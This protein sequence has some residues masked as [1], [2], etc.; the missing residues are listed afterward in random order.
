VRGGVLAGFFTGS[1]EMVQEWINDLSRARIDMPPELTIEYALALGLVGGFED[2][3]AWLARAQVALADDAPP[4]LRARLAM[5]RAITIGSVGEIEPAMQAAYEARAIVERG[6]DQLIDTGSRHV[7]LRCKLFTGDHAAARALFEEDRRL[8]GD[9]EQLDRVILGGMF[10]QVELESGDLEAARVAAERSVATVAKLDAEGHRGTN[11]A[12][13]T[14]G[15]LAYESDQLDAA[16]ALFDRCVTLVWRGRPIFMLLARIELARIWNARGEI[17][18][19][20]V[21][22]DRARDA[23][24]AGIRSPLIDRVEGYRA[25]LLAENDNIAVARDIVERLPTGRQQSVAEIRLDLAE[26][27]ALAAHATLEQLAGSNHSQRE[28]LEFALLDA[29]VALEEST[30]DLEEKLELVLDLGR[31]AGFIRTIADEGPALATALADTLRRQPADSYADTLAPVLERTIAAASARNVPL[32]GGVMLSE[33]ELTV[34]K[35]LATRLATREIAAELYVSMNTFRTHTKS[36]YR[37]LGVDSRAGAVE[38][39]R[40]LGIL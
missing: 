22:L 40:G 39:A 7:L 8:P 19:A 26:R 31:S 1:G 5:A 20:F 23:L 34:L 36:I 12:F 35:Y 10:S 11:D 6:T 32:F 14:L 16:E 21:E 27:K 37:K 29:R 3:R 18:T 30:A 38:A 9:P 2:A 24:P 4:A 17:E 28:E 13:R 33:R 25:R 15:A